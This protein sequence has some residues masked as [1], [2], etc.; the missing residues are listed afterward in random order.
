MRFFPT[1]L[2]G[3]SCIS[4]SGLFKEAL[5]VLVA[6]SLYCEKIGIFMPGLSV[7]RGGGNGE[8]KENRNSS[9]G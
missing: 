7:P 4:N 6:P 2:M 5:P 9:S 3:L 8:Q 1:L